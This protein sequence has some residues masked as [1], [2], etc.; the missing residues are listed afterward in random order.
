MGLG[1]FARQFC[2]SWRGLRHLMV[3]HCPN[4]GVGGR[5]LRQRFLKWRLI[6]GQ[7]FLGLGARSCGDGSRLASFDPALGW[8]SARGASVSSRSGGAR[9][10]CISCLLGLGGRK[11]VHHS[12]DSHVASRCDTQLSEGCSACRVL[13]IAAVVTH[14]STDNEQQDQ[15]Q[16]DAGDEFAGKTPGNRLNSL[17]PAHETSWPARSRPTRAW[18]GF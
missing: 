14:D 11:H 3:T 12:W 2:V 7:S 17:P 9:A 6:I 1:G 8:A 5:E 13:F 16:G 18:Q 15:P 10:F 4:T